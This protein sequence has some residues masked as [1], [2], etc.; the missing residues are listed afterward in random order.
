MTDSL[1]KT[2]L[3]GDLE[4]SVFVEKE[5]NVRCCIRGCHIYHTQWNAE[6]GARLITAPENKT[7][8]SCGRWLRIAVINNGKTVGH[9]PKFLTKL[10][11]FFLKNGGKLHITVTGLRKYSANL[12]QGGL[13]LP[14][15]LFYF[16][17][18][19]LFLHMK[20]KTLAEA[21]KYEKQKKEVVRKKGK[22]KKK[23]LKKEKWKLF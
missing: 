4:I 7:W 17:K 20:E 9:V 5:F 3:F 21:Q 16:V 15:D 19:K 14:A 22:K 18:R 10:I 13:E 6:I 23:K 11:F 8:N 12:K 2:L 1:T